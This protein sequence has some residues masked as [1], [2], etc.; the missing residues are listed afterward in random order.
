M[1]PFQIFENGVTILSASYWIITLCSEIFMDQVEQAIIVKLH[2]VEF[3][4][5][6]GGEGA[7]VKRSTTNSPTLRCLQYVVS[8]G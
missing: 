8:H 7:L 3:K 2:L 5:V 1:F 4:E 6:F